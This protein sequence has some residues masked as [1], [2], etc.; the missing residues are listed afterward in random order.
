MRIAYDP[1]IF[2]LQRYGGISR[3]YYELASRLNGAG[4]AV[5]EIVAPLHRNAYIA[6]SGA[7]TAGRDT[8]LSQFFATPLVL[9]N[10]AR[11]ALSRRVAPP[12]DVLHE[13]YYERTSMPIAAH[14]RVVTVHDM[15]HEKFSE[16]FSRADTTSARKRAA[17]ARADH[18]L[19]ISEQTRRDLQ[20]H[21]ATPDDKIT[22]VHHGF[23]PPLDGVA[24]TVRRPFVLYVGQRAGYK[25]F[26]R[27]ARAFA[28]SERA[29]REFSLVCF[30]GDPFDR[31]ERALFATLGLGDEHVL[32]FGGNDAVLG[33]L[34]RSARALAYPSLYEGFGFPPLEA[35][36]V[37]CPVLA[38]D[39]SSIPEVVGDAALL[40]D[41][42]S[43]DA[44][45]AG[46]ES[47]LYDDALRATLVRAGLSRVSRFSWNDCA[48]RTLAV[49]SRLAS[50]ST[51]ASP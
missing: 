35:M 16:E 36:S 31:S 18:V 43:I 9:A 8:G 5:A 11:L 29:K 28:A 1:V 23:T 14:A 19:C 15:I 50:R 32:H 39:A 12:Y 26:A 37:R 45:R 44:I 10:R 41:P 6:E 49:Y 33:G 47:L 20:A 42:R 4:D 38:S 22:V 3:Y 21:F 48:R 51:S 7:P 17:V 30:G 24:P 34:Y 40:C 46:L 13:T 27:L 25:N 2:C